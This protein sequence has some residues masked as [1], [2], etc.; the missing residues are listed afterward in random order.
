MGHL[1]VES[2]RSCGH[3]TPSMTGL[4]FWG[5]CNILVSFARGALMAGPLLYDGEHCSSNG[6]MAMSRTQTQAAAAP[7]T[8]TNVL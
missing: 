2:G 3:L 4:S 7:L 1:A 6:L 8:G 5:H